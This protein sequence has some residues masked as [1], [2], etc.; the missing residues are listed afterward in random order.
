MFA[1]TRFWAPASALF[2]ALLLLLIQTS[3]AYGQG[4][5]ATVTGRVTDQDGAA[6]PGATVI[7]TNVKTNV[8]I[9]TVTSEGGNYTVP[10][11]QPGEYR[12][13]AEATNFQKFVREGIVLRTSEKVNV[14][15]QLAVGTLDQVVTVTAELSASDTD[16]ST[17]GQVMENKRVAELPLNGR[18]AYML[19]QLTAGTLFT[20]TTF[21]STGFSGTRA[22]D[23]NGS[24]S[25][26]GSRTGNNEFLIDGAPNSATGG[27]Q[28]A[29][30]VDAI[31]EFK[32]SASS[33]D[34]SQGRTGGGVVNLTLKSGTNMIHGSAFEFYRGNALDANTTQNNRNAIPRTG[35][36]FDDF[37]G[38]ISGPIRR[39][40]TFYM[41]FYEGFREKIPFPRT[42]SVATELE[43]QGDFSN[44]RNSAGQL[45]TVYDPLTTKPDPARPGRFIRDPF[46]GNKI[47]ANR[48]SPIALK[49]AGFIPK[50]NVAGDPFTQTNNLAVSPNLGIYSYNSYLV[51]VDHHFNDHHRMFVSSTGNWGVE[52]RN[53]NGFP[54]PSLRGNWP[55][56]RNHY[57]ETI[58]DVYTFNPTTV[59]NLRVSYD[60][61]N[62]FNPIDY[63]ALQGDLGIKT[64]FQVVPPQ[65]PYV[66]IDG[67]QDFFP[68]TY[69]QSVNN[70][71][72]F[73]STLSKM[74]G[75]HFVKVGGDFRSY[76]LNR[77]GLGDGNGRFDFNRGF[78]QRDPQQGD[79]I[80]GNSFAS[81]LLG[82]PSGGGVDVNA[83]SARQYLYYA[84]FVQDDW[85]I[86]KRLTLNLGLRWDY[87]A[88]VTERYN[89]QTAGFDYTS[90]NP[91]KVP[92]LQLKGGLL[93]A[94]EGGNSRAPYESDRTNFQ[95]RVG[96][97]YEIRSGLVFRGNY[98]RS[99]L[100]LTGAGEEGIN[101][102][103]FSRRTGFI[104]SIQTGIPFNTLERPYPEGILQ[105]FGASQGLTAL[106]G[107]GFSFLNP[108]FK[109]P[110]TNLWSV[111]FDIDLPWRVN[112]DIAWVSNHSKKLP[113]NGRSINEVPRAEREKA[114]ERLGG[115]ASYLS[116]NVPNPFAGL[117]P[118]VAL[119]NAQTTRGQL[120]RPFPQFGGITM[121]RVNEGFSDYD[122]L[123][124]TVNKNFSD[125]LVAVF[126]YTLMKNFEAT[127]YLNNG[128]DD[129][130]W[131]SIASIDRTHRVAIT[132]LYD[133]PFGKGKWLLGN[134]S[135]LRD[136]LISGWQL[137]V[138]GEIQS[139]APTAVP[140]GILRQKSAKLDGDARTLDRWFDSS[141]RTNRR[142]DGDYAW[143]QIPPND[144][145][146]IN[147]RFSDIRDPWR[148][149]WAISLF[150]NTLIR[151]KYNF[152]FRAEAFNALN[153][154]IYGG[155]DTGITSTR[156]GQITRNQINFPRH[157]QL[158]FRLAF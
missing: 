141:T 139:G 97:A 54:E 113:I 24:V 122:A 39:D 147:V 52:F 40:K 55:K 27:W 30:V 74:L 133:L 86:T 134:L 75:R 94:G 152:Q 67:Y 14:D 25:I 63:A 119:N 130:P 66:T 145:R 28:Y 22:W 10:Q 116:T 4:F 127:G 44:T 56:H 100:P 20:Q 70:I 124:M 128:Y 157:I 126:N 7:I 118:G 140:G 81:F 92:G 26:H 5:R 41:G 47:P 103:N 59:L 38:V 144:F 114:I 89:R 123:E 61:F 76:R 106:I 138:I 80:S 98:G 11:L 8:A 9:A 60:R 111:G 121:D 87:Q 125:G 90:P 136:K 73:Q 85:K 155:P 88:P 137:N 18:Q 13:T 36:R 35:H 31:E 95:P 72:S 132:A 53:Q 148:P 131:R 150:K 12:V 33:V 102:A 21:G 1:R 115:N 69:S 51:R 2:S 104:S 43:R 79:A 117:V 146:Q 96:L 142:P 108:D 78:T 84:A 46:P 71:Y 77:V 58:D 82:Y 156:F 68:G 42:S 112:M 143:D 48:I 105:P 32:V 99:Y 23:T 158:G 153:T 62:D 3:F 135:G 34:A 101:Q 91:F 45:I 57:M 109:T 17:L 110:Y 19:L 120:L 16:A 129:K 93:F 50:P 15:I 154:P 6:I 151:E 107:S 149:Q 65:Y 49:L 29:P 64:V 37:G 83:T